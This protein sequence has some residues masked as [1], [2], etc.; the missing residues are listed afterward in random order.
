MLLYHHF[1]TSKN[2][3]R[4]I[5][6]NMK[7]NT[8]KSGEQIL[9]RFSGNH[10]QKLNNRKKSIEK[11]ISQFFNYNHG[12]ETKKC[13]SIMDLYV[14]CCFMELTWSIVQQGDK[15]KNKNI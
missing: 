2:T 1:Y 5:L 8:S 3:V 15:N 6:D 14:L 9:S 10:F 11:N 4:D 13:Q 12:V 7:M